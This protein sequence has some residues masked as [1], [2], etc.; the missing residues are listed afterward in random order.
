MNPALTSSKRMDWQ[1]PES[2]LELVRKVGPIALDPCTTQENPTD[3]TVWIY[4]GHSSLV[5][6]GA[7]LAD[8]AADGL[9]SS[10][11]EMVSDTEFGGLVYVNP[12]YGRE[13]PK[14]IDKCVAEA[15]YGAEIV[16]LVPARTDTKW[17]QLALTSADEVLFRKGR[18][19]FVDA[20]TGVAGDAAAFPSMVLYWG[21]RASA[22]RE[23]FDDYGVLIREY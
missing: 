7:L 6:P 9:S 2:F 20:A 1:T 17:G 21:K 8:P 10:W 16:A 5:P 3:A 14:W 23:V 12:P 13:L 19:R 4:P 11:L 15:S 18:I 22:F